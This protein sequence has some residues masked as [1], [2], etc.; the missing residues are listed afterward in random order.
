MAAF[1]STP[2]L[3][4]VSVTTIETECAAAS[5]PTSHRSVGDPEQVPVPGLAEI[6]VVGP[7]SLSVT[8]TLLATAVPPFVT[9]MVKVTALPTVAFVGRTVWLTAMSG[10]G[11]ACHDGTA[12][13]VGAGTIR[14]AAWPSALRD[15]D[16]TA[17]PECDAASVG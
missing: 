12:S 13:L 17:A 9:E 6:S 5:S 3:R 16:L 10:A 7:G 4:T 15:P 2:V 14:V 1:T 8:T 11:N